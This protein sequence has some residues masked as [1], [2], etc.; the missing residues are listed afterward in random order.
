MN[1]NSYVIITPAHNEER[2]IGNTIRSVTSQTVKP[3]KWIVVNDGSTDSTAEIVEACR[4]EHRFIEL[5]NVRRSGE[6][7]FGNK[8]NAFNLGLA[9]AHRL[10]YDYIG[11]LDADISFGPHYFEEILLEFGRDRSLGI[12]GGMVSSSV[13]GRFVRQDVSLDSVAGAVQLFR[14]ACF[15]RIGGYLPLPQGGIDS[16]A[17]IM[18]RM[19]GWQVRTFPEL[20]VLEHRRTGSAKA[21]PLAARVQE[22]RRLYALGYSLSFFGL[23]CLY[24]SLKQPMLLGSLA[25]LYGFLRGMFG[26]EAIV[27]PPE[28]VRFLRAEQRQKLLRKIPGLRKQRTLEIS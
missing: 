4:S 7:H 19:Q 2:F 27:L 24:R 3:V 22:G 17:E 26:R 16:A 1:T 9:Q 11:N 13:N 14:R 8:V 6:R 23:R 10:E 28:V 20:C 15:E 21:G 25:A 12:A 18:A 5:I